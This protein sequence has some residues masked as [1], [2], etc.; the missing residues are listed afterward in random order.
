MVGNWEKLVSKVVV[1]SFI[2]GGRN[3][4][5]RSILNI[6]ASFSCIIGVVF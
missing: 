4:W 5:W 1:E 6:H 2:A 3:S